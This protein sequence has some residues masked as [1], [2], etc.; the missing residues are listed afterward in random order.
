[1]K[2]RELEKVMMNDIIEKFKSF[3][4][5]S[6][7]DG[8]NL[9]EEEVENMKSFIDDFCSLTSKMSINNKF[10]YEI[11]IIFSA[12]MICSMQGPM[13]L[14]DLADVVSNHMLPKTESIKGILNILT[15]IKE[16]PSGLDISA[17]KKIVEKNFKK[18]VSEDQEDPNLTNLRNEDGTRMSVSQV[19]ELFNESRQNWFIKA[20]W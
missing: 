3:N 15:K 6:V 10:L 13:A 1:M 19:E 18:Y 8:L 17:I 12:I 16:G 5:T 4:I 20:L 11:K 2:E 9:N 7:K 14:F